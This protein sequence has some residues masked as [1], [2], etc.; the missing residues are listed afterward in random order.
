MQRARAYLCYDRANGPQ[1]N[2]ALP[3]FPEHSR[4]SPHARARMRA[5]AGPDQTKITRPTVGHGARRVAFPL[6][7]FAM[8]PTADHDA[9]GR[10]RLRAVRGKAVPAAKR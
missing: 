7:N 1:D 4:I 3:S 8:E 2:R 5:D 9:Y 6:L 10:H